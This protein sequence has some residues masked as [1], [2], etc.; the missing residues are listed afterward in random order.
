MKVEVELRKGDP[1]IHFGDDGLPVDE[2]RSNVT[3]KARAQLKEELRTANVTV[4]QFSQVRAA[5][6]VMPFSSLII[7]RIWRL[8][9]RRW[10][11]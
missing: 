7:D 9:L 11:W 2:S 10:R 4:P 5:A 1:M 6:R 8:M 3:G